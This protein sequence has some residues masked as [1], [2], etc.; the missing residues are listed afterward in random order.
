MKIY[1]RRTINKDQRS[2]YSL[3][4]NENLYQTQFKLDSSNLKL[5]YN[6]VINSKMSSKIKTLFMYFFFN[7]KFKFL[8]F[9]AA[10]FF[11]V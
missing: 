10:T 2:Q 3:F 8:E 1:L 5:S 11:E 4:I 9:S 6:I 7:D